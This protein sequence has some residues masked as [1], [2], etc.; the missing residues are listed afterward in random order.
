MG[1]V[2]TGFMRFKNLQTKFMEIYKPRKFQWDQMGRDQY[3]NAIIKVKLGN[4]SIVGRALASVR[5]FR[6]WER[7]RAL[8]KRSLRSL[9]T[10]VPNKARLTP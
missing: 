8:S 2:W 10:Y 5:S 1:F 3:K 4:A 6:G 7:S 9:A